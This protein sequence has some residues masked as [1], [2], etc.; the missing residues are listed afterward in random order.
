MKCQSPVGAAPKAYLSR[1][2]F[3]VCIGRRRVARFYGG[4]IWAEGVNVGAWGESAAMQLTS[5]AHKTLDTN[6]NCQEDNFH[7]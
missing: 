4:R 7:C 6:D 5:S 3:S 2:I 1:S